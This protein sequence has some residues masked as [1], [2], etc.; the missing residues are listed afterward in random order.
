MTPGGPRNLPQPHMLPRKLSQ[1]Q[2]KSRFPQ[3]A[4]MKGLCPVTYL[5]GKQRYPIHPYLHKSNSTS[6]SLCK[7]I[8][9]R[10]HFKIKSHFWHFIFRLHLFIW[11]P[12]QTTVL[13]S[14]DLK[15]WFEERWNLLWN[16]GKRSTFLRQS[17][18]K[19]SFWGTDIFINVMYF[20]IK[21]LSQFSMPIV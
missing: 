20:L 15:I 11:G 9:L 5:D 7:H 19:I 13:L 6:I 1:G 14:L 2:L 10:A 8:S 18:S 17:R 3:Q 16:T 4:E 12:N 21:R